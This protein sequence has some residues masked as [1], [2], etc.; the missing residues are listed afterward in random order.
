MGRFASGKRSMM[1]SDRSGQS[2][3]YQEMVQEW[4]GSM[5]HISEYEPKHPQLDP[6]V[7]GADPQALLNNRNQDFQTPRLTIGST[8]DSRLYAD[9]GGAGMATALLTLPGDFAFIATGMIPANPDQ[10]A[11]GRY[12]L[13]ALGR[14]TVSIS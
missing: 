13:I 3:P 7:Y 11:K 2:F 8:P 4:Q 10:Q 5:V 12:T 1:K 14:V 9:S 6:K